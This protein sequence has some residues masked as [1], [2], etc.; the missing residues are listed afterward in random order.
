M[1]FAR[2]AC[3][4]ILSLVP[5]CA[6]LGTST[7]G[8][9]KTNAPCQSSAVQLIDARREVERYARAVESNPL[10]PEA[11]RE[12]GRA[13][14]MAVDASDEAQRE[15]CEALR[16]DPSSAA[17]YTGLGWSYLRLNSFA[18]CVRINMRF[19]DPDAQPRV[20]LDFFDQALAIDPKDVEAHLGRAKAYSLLDFNEQAAAACRDALACCPESGEALDL[21]GEVLMKLRRYSEAIE[22]YDKEIEVCAN[23]SSVQ[24]LSPLRSRGR[25]EGIWLY[26]LVGDT[27]LDLQRNT[28]AIERY[29]QALTLADDRC[30]LHHRLALAYS[31]IGEYQKSQS[32]FEA[33]QAGCSATADVAGWCHFYNDLVNRLGRD[34]PNM[35]RVTNLMLESST[36][37]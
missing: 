5:A 18:M 16:L 24:S 23:G 2:L 11:H 36:L 12:L 30:V 8:R 31:K 37:R 35:L 7:G 27:L 17:A 1:K 21:L 26:V 32:H 6:G 10:S 3:L 14:L 28:E 13:Y 33:L 34:D 20:A 19:Y 4:V 25:I 29:G 15:F 9:T 22:A